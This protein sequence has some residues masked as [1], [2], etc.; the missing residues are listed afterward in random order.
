MQNSAI[1]LLV[2]GVLFPCLSPGGQLSNCCAFFPADEKFTQPL[3]AVGFI[4][5]LQNIPWCNDLEEDLF[6]FLLLSLSS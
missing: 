3:A 2:Q 4:R 1:E 5:V 6:S